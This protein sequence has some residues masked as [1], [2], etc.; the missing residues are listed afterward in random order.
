MNEVP[1][2]HTGR[3]AP[4][5]P[6]LEAAA[7]RSPGRDLGRGPGHPPTHSGRPVGPPPV[8]KL[9]FDAPGL[10]VLERTLRQDAG[11]VL[12]GLHEPGPVRAAVVDRR[13]PPAMRAWGLAVEHL[14]FR[15]QDASGVLRRLRLATTLGGGLGAAAEAGR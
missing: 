4:R 13:A 6:L 10:H 12:A 1:L 14:A 8:L 11:E 9:L 5:L 2:H 15:S 7:P 3:P